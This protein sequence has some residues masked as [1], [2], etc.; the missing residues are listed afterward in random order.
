MLNSK[1]KI[2]AGIAMLSLYSFV[3][4]AFRVHIAGTNHFI[5]LIWNWMLAVIP[6]LLSLLISALKDKNIMQVLAF[7]I[8][9][10]LWLLVF[11]NAPYL[12][13]DLIHLKKR[14]MVPLWLDTLML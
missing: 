10:L 11:P 12:I 3:L 7:T 13:T 4:L 9:G 1:K 14:T 6:L 5:F 8:L 2:V